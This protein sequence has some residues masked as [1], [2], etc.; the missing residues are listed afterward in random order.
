M[1]SE[2][3][4]VRI[5]AARERAHDRELNF[6]RMLPAMRCRCEGSSKPRIRVKAASY[7]WGVPETSGT[8]AG[9]E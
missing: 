2:E 8:S 1:L 9:I 6:K 7:R 3:L 4:K 5:Q